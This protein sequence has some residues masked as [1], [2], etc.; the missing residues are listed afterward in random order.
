MQGKLYSLKLDAPIYALV[1]DERLMTDA[2]CPNARW[3]DPWRLG[4]YTA[5]RRATE[6]SM[7]G[8]TAYQL[9]TTREVGTALLLVFDPRGRGKGSVQ[10]FMIQ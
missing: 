5:L 2:R 3:D 7:A 10:F 8:S 4:R 6:E 9:K 1:Y